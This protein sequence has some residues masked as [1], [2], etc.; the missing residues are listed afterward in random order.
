LICCDIT[1]TSGIYNII[2]QYKPDEIYNMAAASHV[3][4]SF[5]QPYVAMNINCIGVLNILEGMKKFS[6][7]SKLVQ[8]STS[9]LWGDNVNKEGF[10]DEDTP[11]APNSPYAC[12]K[13][14]A[15]YL[16]KVY[17]ESYDLFACCSITHNHESE[18]RGEEFVTRK[19]TKWIGVFN[20]FFES[21]GPEFDMDDE[22]IYPKYNQGISLPKLRLG[23]IN[24]CRSWTHASDVVRGFWLMLQQEEPCDYVF[25]SE[26]EH[27]IQEF[28]Y[29]AFAVIGIDDWRPYIY[30]DPEFYR[31][32]DVSYLNGCAD[33]AKRDLGWEP[34]IS[35]EELVHRMVKHDLRST[36]FPIRFVKDL[37]KE[38]V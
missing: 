10:Q 17:R 37:K 27:S 5:K 28:L 23:N 21:Y 30:I 11:F 14:A 34:T 35:F 31:P 13:L 1:D 36:C 4:E 33:R 24:S 26:Q 38:K 20:P 16:V 2:D 19:I 7:Q 3:G 6:P 25:S 8:A 9:E 15:H 32:N 22:T 18:H 29:T 12:S